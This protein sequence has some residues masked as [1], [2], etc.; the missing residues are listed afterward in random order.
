MLELG[1]LL[2]MDIYIWGLK[3]F[4]ERIKICLYDSVSIIKLSVWL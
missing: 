2:M 4:R 1:W 3:E